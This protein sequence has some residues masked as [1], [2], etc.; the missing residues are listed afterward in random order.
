MIK[1][2]FTLA[3]ILALSGCIADESTVTT[4]ESAAGLAALEPTLASL[5]V[6]RGFPLFQIRCLRAEARAFTMRGFFQGGLYPEGGVYFGDD[7]MGEESVSPAV[8]PGS[9]LELFPNFG[10]GLRAHIHV[11]DGALRATTEN[12][13]ETLRCELFS[14]DHTGSHSTDSARVL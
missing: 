5:T 6:D 7:E 8:V 2:I 13:V 10:S 4:A 3:T 1:P 14:R 12:P 9:F 11:V